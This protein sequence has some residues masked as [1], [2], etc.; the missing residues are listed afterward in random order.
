MECVELVRK[1]VLCGVLVVCDSGASQIA[2]GI[3]ACV[4]FVPSL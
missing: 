4:V 2:I 3:I 1:F